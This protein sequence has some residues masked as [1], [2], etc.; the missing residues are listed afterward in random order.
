MRDTLIQVQVL[1]TQAVRYSGQSDNGW[2]LC[3]QRLFELDKAINNLSLTEEI[4]LIGDN[5][6]ND[7]IFSLVNTG[8]PELLQE[9]HNQLHDNPTLRPLEN[10]LGNCSDVLRYFT[11]STTTAVALI[12]QSVPVSSLQHKYRFNN[13]I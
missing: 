11:F 3:N 10:F 13:S 7:E 4:R 6:S 12:L 9:I 5:V 1:L 2:G 8:L